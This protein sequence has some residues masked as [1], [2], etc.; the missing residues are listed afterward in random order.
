MKRR[1]EE[2]LVK[3]VRKWL[4]KGGVSFFK[5]MREKHGSVSPIFM[6]DGI[7][8][9]VHFREGMQVRNFLRKTGL[10]KGWGAHDYDNNWMEIIKKA[11]R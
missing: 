3:R 6:E 9:P 8:H 4:G 7:P 1:K 10:C 5:S 11:I 2:K